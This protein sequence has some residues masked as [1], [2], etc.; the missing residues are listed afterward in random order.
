VVECSLMLV[1][2]ESYLTESL[3]RRRSQYYPTP[4]RTEF[5]G[6]A[7]PHFISLI[8]DLKVYESKDSHP[9]YLLTACS[10][11]LSSSA[12]R[13]KPCYLVP[14]EDFIRKLSIVRSTVV[15]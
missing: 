11:K 5:P 10:V 15:E 14:D 1:S 2:G 4:T 6:G 9:I 12:R 8:V 13:T 3:L 7:E